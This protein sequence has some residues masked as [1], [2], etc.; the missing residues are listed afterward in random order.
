MG[1]QVNDVIVPKETTRDGVIP[2]KLKLLPFWQSVPD[3]LDQLVYR[4]RYFS[5]WWRLCHVG[6]S[7]SLPRI[8]E[9]LN[10]IFAALRKLSALLRG[11]VRV[12][13][14]CT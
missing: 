14:Q 11:N 12:H 3:A 4:N 7:A 13:S 10:G 8:A 6:S 5:G 1:S 9:A 2:R